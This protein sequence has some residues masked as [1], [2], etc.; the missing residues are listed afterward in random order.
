MGKHGGKQGGRPLT[1]SEPLSERVM[2]RLM[3]SEAKAL[4]SACM[5][6]MSRSAVLRHALRIF[7]G[8]TAMLLM[9][10]C[11][12]PADQILAPPTKATP[13]CFASLTAPSNISGAQ[14]F[15]SGDFGDCDFGRG[16]DGIRELRFATLSGDLVVMVDIAQIAAPGNSYDIGSGYVSLQTASY[17]SCHGVVTW[18]SDLPDWSVTVDATCD[19][20][21]R[22][23]GTWRGN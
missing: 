15:D 8:L 9:V 3:P 11:D 1:V 13:T 23:V 18:T 5:V 22:V 19:D 2:V 16:N 12:A 21:A 14:T 10:G 17:A 4:D 20:G 7:L 6:G